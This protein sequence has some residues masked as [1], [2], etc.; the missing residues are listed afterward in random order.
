MAEWINVAAQGGVSAEIERL[1]EYH[2]NEYKTVVALTAFQKLLDMTD[3]LKEADDRW[4]AVHPDKA[5]HFGL[6][7]LGPELG[8]AIEPYLKRR[9][10]G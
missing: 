6:D 2:Y 4:R 8:D 9:N 3:T 5:A 10:R 1:I 7:A